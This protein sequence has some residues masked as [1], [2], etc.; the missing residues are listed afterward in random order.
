MTKNELLNE[1]ICRM[2]VGAEAFCLVAKRYYRITKDVE[3]RVEE[4]NN[5][6]S[7]KNGDLFHKH[8]DGPSGIWCGVRIK[9]KQ[10]DYQIY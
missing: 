1:A 8:Y 7:Y 9:F 4:L 6:Y 5:I 2:P 10:E 3:F